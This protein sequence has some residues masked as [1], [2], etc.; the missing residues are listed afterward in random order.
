MPSNVRGYNAHGEIVSKRFTDTDKWDRPWFRK[1][2]PKYKLFWSYMTDKCDMIGVWYVDFE[3]AEFVI[4]EKLDPAEA[5]RLFQKQIRVIDSTRWL[6]QDFVSFQYGELKENNNLHRSVA[7][8]LRSLDSA[9]EQPLNSPSRGAKEKERVKD[10]ESLE[11]GVGETNLQTVVRGWKIQTGV[12]P[13]DKAWDQAHYKRHLRPAQ[14]LLNL[15]SGDVDA[16]LDCI[17][18]VYKQLVEKKG[19]D[20]SLQGVVNNSGRFRQE[21]LERKQKQEVGRA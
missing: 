11:G 19:L 8:R 10:K 3:M 12:D 16:A 6:I 15:F 20:L 1:L 14:S 17:E 18:T 2:P 21:W 7:S 9:P 4:G 5:A 13:E